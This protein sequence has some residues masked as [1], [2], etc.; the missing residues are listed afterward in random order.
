MKRSIFWI[1][2]I[3]LIFLINSVWAADPPIAVLAAAEDGIT[4]FFNDD[5]IPA[6]G[7]GFQ[8]FTVNPDKILDGSFA[9]DLHKIAEPTNLWQF[10]VL[11]GTKPIALL[12]VDKLN[13]EY[14]P[15]SIGASNFSY[16]LSRVTSAWPEAEGYRLRLIRIYQA[17]S[18]FIEVSQGEEIIG[19]VPFESGRVTMSL[20]TRDCI[21]FDVHTSSSIINKIRPIVR[22]NISTY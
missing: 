6:L 10:I 22:E 15:V 19:F 18:D 16:Q 8:I 11:S 3:I 20:A 2:S 13:G 12:S 17:T 1:L 21:P 4:I 7:K 9:E 5:D 14:T